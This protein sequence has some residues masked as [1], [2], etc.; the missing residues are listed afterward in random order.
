MVSTPTAHKADRAHTGCGWRDARQT[1]QSGCPR[2]PQ[3]C[4]R[5][6]AIHRSKNPKP[7]SRRDMK[8]RVDPSGEGVGRRSS[9]GLLTAGPRL[10]G[11]P[12]ELA[13]VGRSATHRSNTPT[14]PERSEAKNNARPSAEIVGLTSVAA[15]LTTGPRL[16]TT[17][18]GSA[19]VPRVATQMSESPE[20][21]GRSEAK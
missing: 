20:P 19:V 7:P 21:P 8:N 11:G 17:E 16:A 3:P 6:G 15:L 10:I 13:V 5:M 18:K 14:V 12:K 2:R 4:R 1:R 9:A